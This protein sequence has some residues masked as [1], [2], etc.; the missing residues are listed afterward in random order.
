M[1]NGLIGPGGNV[2]VALQNSAG[3][4][5]WEFYFTGGNQFYSISGGTTDVT[6]TSGGMTIEFALTSPTTYRT[7]I[8]ANGGIPRVVQGNLN[9]NTNS[10]VTHFKAWNNN[11]GPGSDYDM[12]FNNIYIT[13]NATSLVGGSLSTSVVVLSSS[14]LIAVSPARESY[15]TVPLSVISGAKTATVA[16][17]FSYLN[18]L[19][20]NIDLVG[21]IGGNVS[22][23]A[24]VG[25]IVCYGEGLSLVVADFTISSAPIER[26]RIVLPQRINHI[27]L[28][29]NIAFVATGS[30]GVYAVD[31]STPTAPSILGFYDTDGLAYCISVISNIAYVADNTAGLLILNV[32]NPSAIH[33]TATLETQGRVKRISAGQIA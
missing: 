26:G 24:V 15:G 33:K 8:S 2:G 21:H 27:A 5:L 12:Y 11:A 4:T 16:N 1:D 22:A 18:P 28:V 13:S 23:V 10:I 7:T 32:S 6:W 9:A 19:G 17:G 3:L 25:P 30:S 29:S 20:S 14:E 31:V